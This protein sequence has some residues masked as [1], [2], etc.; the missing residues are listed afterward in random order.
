[1][2][3]EEDVDR[4]AEV[5]VGEMVAALDLIAPI[6]HV[7][8]RDRVVP[9][10]LR[11][12]TRETM[13]ARDDAACGKDWP[14]FL[15]LHNLAAHRVRRDRVATNLELFSRYKGDTNQIW[16]LA[17]SLTVRGQ[18]CALPP[19]L[20]C[21][22]QLVQGE[23]KL[24]DVMNRHYISKTAKIWQGF[25]AEMQQQHHHHQQQQQFGGGSN[26]NSSSGS[27]GSTSTRGF[28][29]LLHLLVCALLFLFLCPLCA[30]EG[31]SAEGHCEAQERTGYKDGW[32]LYQHDQGPGPGTGSPTGSP[33]KQELLQQE[34]PINIQDRQCRPH[35]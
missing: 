9:L 7:I 11:K 18:S 16:K 13:V 8:I 6:R 5:L 17:N 20:D 24:A 12:E 35:L 28:L 29:H 14:L 25:V 31:G 3:L 2:L 27:S 26:G 23:E 33:V 34:V 15:K 30:G 21:E 32:H 4:I 19:K 1:M 22:G 10:F